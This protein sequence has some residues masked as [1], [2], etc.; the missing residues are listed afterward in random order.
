[1]LKFAIFI[2]NKRQSDQNI[3]ARNIL[4]DPNKKEFIE[5]VLKQTEYRNVDAF[6]EDIIY[7][8]PVGA[9]IIIDEITSDLENV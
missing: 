5:K 7:E 8:K 4:K 1:L 3:F 9:I 6:F 2:Q